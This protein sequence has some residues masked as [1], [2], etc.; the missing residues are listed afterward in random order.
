MMYILRGIGFARLFLPKNPYKSSDHPDPK[1]EL[2]V[3]AKYK[4]EA[5]CIALNLARTQ[6]MLLTKREADKCKAPQLIGQRVRA[7]VT[8]LRF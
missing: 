5:E 8:V 4:L 1:Q 3:V 2:G 7:R 6:F